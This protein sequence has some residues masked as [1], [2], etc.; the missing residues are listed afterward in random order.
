MPTLATFCLSATGKTRNVR[1]RLYPG[2]T[3]FIGVVKSGDPSKNYDVSTEV[4]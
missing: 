3:G 2:L 4:E 1:F